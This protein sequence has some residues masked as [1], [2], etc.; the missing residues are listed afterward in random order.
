MSC[1]IYHYSQCSNDTSLYLNTSKPDPDLSDDYADFW[2][3]RLDSSSPYSEQKKT[4]FTNIALTADDQLCQRTAFALSQIFSISPKFLTYSSLSEAYLYFYDYFSR[5]CKTDYKKLLKEIAFSAKLGMQLSHAGSA[6]LRYSYDTRGQALFPDENNAR[7]SMQL[8]TIGLDMLNMDGTPIRDDQGLIIPTYNSRHILTNARVWT[9]L[10]LVARRGNYEEKG[11]NKINWMD[12]MNLNGEKHDWFPKAD[13]LDNWIGDRYPLC[14]DL[15]QQSF[16][17]TGAVYKLLGRSSSPRYQYDP[18][19]WDG[20]G[21]IKK[22][23]L[24]TTS[25]NLY[26]ELKCTDNGGEC[27]YSSV[28]TLTSDLNCVGLECDVDTLRV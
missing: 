25:S 5:N 4:V 20:N 23:T 3:W 14:T 26:N 8:Q 10:N 6:S 21:S 28:I 22:M 17:K 12:P 13:L 2:N 27:I 19:D 16:L 24:S 1:Y 9:G 15:P 7:E 18:K 11:P